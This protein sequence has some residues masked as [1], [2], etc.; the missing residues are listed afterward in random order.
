MTSGPVSDVV[1]ASVVVVDDEASVVE[2]V[3]LVELV[4]MELSVGPGTVSGVEVVVVELVLVVV[5]LVLVVVDCVVVVSPL[6]PWSPLPP[7]PPLPQCLTMW[8]VASSPVSKLLSGLR[9]VKVTVPCVG[10]SPLA[11]Q[12]TFAPEFFVVSKC[13]SVMPVVPGIVVVTST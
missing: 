9:I 4:G 6:S 12:M 3:E 10:S 7:L 8:R 13:P 1:V 5:E 11:L 2:L